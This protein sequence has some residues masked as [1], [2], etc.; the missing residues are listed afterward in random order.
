MTTGNGGG[1]PTEEEK[2][3]IREKI[4]EK[5]DEDHPDETKKDGS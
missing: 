1:D 4:L 5:W 2:K 3:R